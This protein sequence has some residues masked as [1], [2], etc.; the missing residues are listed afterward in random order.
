LNAIPYKTIIESNILIM[1]EHIL[2]FLK[3]PER[4]QKDIPMDE[5]MVTIGEPRGL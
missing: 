2:L 1:R 4:T 5:F 3:L